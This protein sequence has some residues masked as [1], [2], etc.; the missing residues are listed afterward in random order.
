[1]QPPNCYNWFDSVGKY[2]M[3]EEGVQLTEKE[4][5]L[6]SEEMLIL[7]KLFITEG[8][9]KIRLTGGEPMVR[10]DLNHIISEF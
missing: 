2:C 10:S 6:T 9:T 1:M 7:A 3:P 4:R 5:L 8:V